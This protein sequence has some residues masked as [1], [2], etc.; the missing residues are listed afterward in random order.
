MPDYTHNA[1]QGTTDGT[2]WMQRT[3][4]WMFRWIPLPVMYGIM[5]LVIPFYMLLDSRARRASWQFHRK[6]MGKSVLGSIAG[7]YRSEFNLGMVVLD[8]FAMYAGKQFHIAGRNLSEFRELL[9]KES[10][11]VTLS[12]HAG[13]YEIA[14]YSL[15]A[16]PKEM[17][18][19]VYAGETKT[20]MQGREKLFSEQGTTM[21][22]VSGDLSHIFTLNA[23]LSRG[24]IVSMPGDRLFGSRKSVKVPFLGSDA[25]F[26]QGPFALVAAKDVPVLSI[27]VMKEGLRTYGISINRL[28]REGDGDLSRDERIRALAGRYASSLEKT[29]REYPYQWYNFYDF[30]A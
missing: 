17:F 27:F 5:S 26:P 4:I 13:N 6:R 25:S 9:D 30:W 11:M 20:V 12:S 19:L 3:L 1:W 2:P 14:G 15:N 18:V 24:A 16:F 28:D 21:V 29:V 22:P 8:R 10:G 7:I 23:A